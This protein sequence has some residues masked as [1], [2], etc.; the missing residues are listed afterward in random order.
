LN[1][2]GSLKAD[3]SK[4]VLIGDTDYDIE[5]AEK[6]GIDNVIVSWGYGEKD[7]ENRAMYFVRSVGELIE[8]LS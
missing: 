7:V 2:V 4:C 8:L 5:G 3:K 6:V 1:A